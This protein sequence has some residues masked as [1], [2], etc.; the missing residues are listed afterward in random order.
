V[1]V[2]SETV[3]GHFRGFAPCEWCQR[4]ASLRPHH[5]WLRR[6][7]GGGKRLDH[8]WNLIALCALCHDRAHLA[9][10]DEGHLCRQGFLLAV[11]VREG[12]KAVSIEDYLGWLSRQDKHRPVGVQR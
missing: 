10:S 11:A 2:R 3:L 12:V 4:F 8:P 9:P 6:G 1:K 7:M 5:Y